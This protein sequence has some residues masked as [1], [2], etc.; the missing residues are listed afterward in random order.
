MQ[1]S[2]DLVEV[3]QKR[4]RCRHIHAAGHQCG[5]PALRHEQFC[6]YHHTTRRPAPPVGKFR[7]I[8]SQEPFLLPIIEDRASAL[9]VASHLLSRIATND[10]D[11]DRAGKMLYNLQIITTLLPPEPDPAASTAESGTEPPPKPPLVEELIHDETLG[12]IAPITEFFPLEPPHSRQ[13][14]ILSTLTAV[15]AIRS[16]CSSSREASRNAQSAA[17]NLD[18]EIWV[19]NTYNKQG[20]NTPAS[21]SRSQPSN[22]LR[23]SDFVTLE[24]ECPR[25]LFVP[26]A[27]CKVPSPFPATSP[28]LTGTPCSPALPKAPRA[29]R[30]FQRAP[31]R[32]PHSPAWKRSAQ[33]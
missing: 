19:K 16:S 32:T 31:T 15:A 5:S 13:P 29:C 17:P 12:T 20:R 24:S 25:K 1:E 7:Y 8:D 22:P 28:S 2:T 23:P 3:T 33:P 27:A 4:I 11:V 6:Y 21:T 26:P 30:T 10:L 9:V 14:A 18:S